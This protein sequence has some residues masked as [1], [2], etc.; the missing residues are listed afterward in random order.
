MN[1]E[2]KKLQKGV[3]WLKGYAALSTAALILLGLA[4]F[5]SQYGS[6]RVLR[7]RG[8]VIEDSAGRERILI[9]A[10]IPAAKNRVRTDLSR[11]MTI[12]GRRFPKEYIEWYQHYRHDMNGVLILDEKGFDK[13]ALGDPVPDPNIGRR[14]GPSTGVIVNDDEGFERTGYG[15]LKVENRYR[16]VLGLD[17]AEGREGVTLA[18]SDDGPL[19][20]AVEQADRAIYL[21][22]SPPG[23][24]ITGMPDVFHGLV[25]RSGGKVKYQ[26]NAA[27]T[28]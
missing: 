13:A 20:L 28:K 23:S 21:G 11:A 19:C 4:V 15:L 27:Q 9:G 24:P 5:R 16:A 25:L 1:D 14:I 2:V 12:W 22:M 7:A 26:I 17:S 6:E 18:L 3:R 10:P 8:L